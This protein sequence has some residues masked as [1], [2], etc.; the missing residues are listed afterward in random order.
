MYHS[1]SDRRIQCRA[2]NIT[3]ELGQI[4]H[5]FSDKTGTLT[6]NQMLFK[7]CT[8]GGLDYAYPPREVIGNYADCSTLLSTKHVMYVFL[9]VRVYSGNYYNPILLYLF[10][11]KYLG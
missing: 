7:R 5:V 6:E 10:A 4:E 8:I 3:E 1:A 11:L 2:L 9:I